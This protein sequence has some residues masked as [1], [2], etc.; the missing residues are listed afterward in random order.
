[1]RSLFETGFATSG[2]SFGMGQFDWGS[3]I[4]AG[5]QSGVQFYFQREA[6]KSAEKERRRAEERAAE[7]ARRAQEAVERADEEETK[8]AE[9]E[10]AAPAGEGISTSTLLLAG[11]GAVAL[12]GLILILK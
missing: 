9:A 1:M 2:H 7:A 5:L 3:L 4:S 11:G 6:L 8:A 12:I 10:R